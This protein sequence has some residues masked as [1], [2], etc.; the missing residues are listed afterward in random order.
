M[1]RLTQFLAQGRLLALIVLAAALALHYLDPATVQLMRMHGFDVLQEIFPR[2][3]GEHPVTIVDLDEESLKALGQWPWPRTLI[4]ELTDR[5]TALGAAVVGFDVYFPEPDRMSPALAAQNFAGLDPATRATL[6]TL[7]SNDS[8]FAEALRRGRVVL[9]ETAKERDIG[10]ADLPVNR[11]PL[12]R[13]GSDPLRHLRRYPG[14][15]RA[16]PELE[17]AAAGLGM[18]TIEPEADGII[19]RVPLVLAIGSELFPALSF[20][21]LR[22]VTGESVAVRTGPYGI[23]GLLINPFTIPTDDNGSVWVHFAPHEKSIYVSAKDVINGSVDPARIAGKLVLVGTSATGL[24]DNKTT[25][26]DPWLPGVEV[27][28]QL[29][30]TVMSGTYLS[31]PDWA[32]GAERLLIIAAG[33]IMIMLVSVTGARWTLLVLVLIAAA[34]IAGDA[35]L[36]RFH[37]LMID[38]SLPL[39]AS[40]ALY[41]LLVYANYSREESQRREIRRAFAQY[42]S[43]VVV[44]QLA[45]DPSRLKLGGDHRSMTFLFSDIRGFT[46]ISEHYAE[47]PG[48]L[49]V[50][51]NR[52]MTPMTDTIQAHRG[53]IDKYIGDAIM[54]FWNA[55]LDDAVHARDACFAALDM[56]RELEALNRTLAAEADAGKAEQCR[57]ASANGSVM[58]KPHI[59]TR[60]LAIGIGINTGDCI[61]GN[62]GSEFRKNYTV[63]GDA[64]NLAARLESQSKNYG[65]TIVIGEETYKQVADLAGIELD[66]IAVKGKVQAVHIFTLL[67]GAELA[68]TPAYR[69]LRARHDAMLAAYRG[70]DW[71]EARGLIASC[72]PLS[73]QLDHLYDLYETRIDLFE[74]IPPP[75]DWDGVHIAETK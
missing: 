16:I 52:Y 75:P 7:P 40:A 32:A 39:L 24:G 11:A 29:L 27:H 1:H 42:L 51:I 5:L 68:A 4:A 22:V 17:Q 2:A 57:A 53:T 43:P 70:Q 33:L 44:E 49:I 66:L 30:E 50:L 6:E 15:I 71:A 59:F 37:A 19:R 64:V 69:D 8:V 72:R 25:P 61:V 3:E 26:L 60:S 67:G 38:I 56:M 12:A 54:A 18:V 23:E 34:L 35:Y 65:V 62:M 48:G 47:D 74:T 10:T 73:R 63:L 13:L 45:R 41:T 55:P 21:M 36:Y 58:S 28:A 20:E 46:A 31:R 9:G 14:V